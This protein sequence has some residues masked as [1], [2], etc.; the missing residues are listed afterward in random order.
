MH[1]ANKKN[2]VLVKW[3]PDTPSTVPQPASHYVGVGVAVVDDQNR[4][5]VVQEKFG[6][7]SRRGKDFWKMPTGLVDNGEDIEAAAVRE[8]L[9]ETGIRVRFDGV[10]AF[11]QNHK[12]GVE[13]K[14][15]L[16]FLCKAT[17]LSHHIT[18]QEAEIAQAAWMPLTEYMS[19]PLWPEYS[20][21]WWMS[22]LAAES[23]LKGSGHLPGERLATVPVEFVPTRLPLGSRPGHNY[24]YSAAS[25]P[26]PQGDHDAAKARWQ[27][28]KAALAKL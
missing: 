3:L 21:Y 28:A 4:I 16:F 22:Q 24:I 13:G 18:I 15:D 1:H 7:A 27:A 19:K 2:M 25:C 10:L 17:P 20:A 26:P 5:L 9:E 14:T 12:T 23:F 6:P 8:V 11:R